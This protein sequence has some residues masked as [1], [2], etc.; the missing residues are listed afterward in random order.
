MR[1]KTLLALALIGCSPVA[2]AQAP[3]QQPVQLVEVRV[4]VM[5]EDDRPVPSMV[6]VQLLSSQRTPIDERMTDDN[7]HVSFIGVRP[8]SYFLRAH[9]VDVEDTTGSSF[10]IMPRQHIHMESL[11]VRRKPQ[12]NANQSLPGQPI[13]HVPDPNVPRNA[14]KNYGKG[15]DA[16]RKGSLERAK[17]LFEEAISQHPLYASAHNSLGVTYMRMGK[18]QEGRAAFEKAVSLDDRFA[19]P[20]LNLGML[21]MEENRLPDAQSHLSKCVANDPANADGLARL[22]YVELLMGNVDNAIVN[23]RKVHAVP[24]Q[25]FEH[26][27]IVAARALRAKQMHNEAL[28]EYKQFL[29][30]APSSPTAATARKEM[31]DLEKQKP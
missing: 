4:R 13:V 1:L 16:L 30:E 14:G 21:A 20:Y 6:M 10:V 23:A 2:F 22:A 19:L 5:F 24:H 18:P 15:M 11:S 3:G 26:S 9:G 17:T 28:A 29:S 31:A 12:A 8:G 25:G 27:H 7:G